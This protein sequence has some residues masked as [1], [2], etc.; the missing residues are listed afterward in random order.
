MS[1]KQEENLDYIRKAFIAEVSLKYKA[2]D[3]KHK[4]G[5]LVDFNPATLLEN[6]IEEA[7]DQVVYLMTLRRKLL[8]DL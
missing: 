5:N 3:K 8:N 1:P 7:I 2:G 4:G 6:A